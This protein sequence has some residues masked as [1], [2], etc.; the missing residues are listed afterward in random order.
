MWSTK[1]IKPTPEERS[2]LYDDARKIAELINSTHIDFRGKLLDA[3]GY[4]LASKQ[5]QFT[6]KVIFNAAKEYGKL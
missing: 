1:M 2:K 4:S 3:V 5:Q 6:A